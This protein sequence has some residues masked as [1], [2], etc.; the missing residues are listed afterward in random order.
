MQEEGNLG[1]MLKRVGIRFLPFCCVCSCI[2]LCGNGQAA[3]QLSDIP[4]T[5]AKEINYLLER[6]LSL[7]TKMGLLNL[8]EM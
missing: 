5:A 3:A 6:K 1:K 8:L 4:S 7:V 2:F